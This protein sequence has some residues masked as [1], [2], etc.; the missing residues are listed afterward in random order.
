MN[1]CY[2]T[3]Y[4]KRSNYPLIWYQHKNPCDFEENVE[5]AKNIYSFSS[6]RVDIKKR[7]CKM[8][9]RLLR[10]RTSSITL[11]AINPTPISTIVEASGI[12]GDAVVSLGS[13]PQVHCASAG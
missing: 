6:L 2:Q 7:G 9:Y 13:S 11:I 3:S 8:D 4:H 10:L 12:G 5:W 1:L